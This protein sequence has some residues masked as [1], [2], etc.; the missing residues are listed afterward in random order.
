MQSE[1]AIEDAARALLACEDERRARDPLTAADWPDLTVA[2][3]YRVQDA[4]AR[5]RQARGERIVG[6]KMGLTSRAKQAT[7]GV[8]VP[9]VAWVTDRMRV[10]DEEAPPLD[11]FIH[12]R[13]EPELFFRLGRPLSG[14]ALTREDAAAAVDLVVAGVD[15]I[16]SRY[17]DFRFTLADVVAD[18][19]SSAGFIPGPVQCDPA[20]LDL[21]LESVIVEQDGV[22]IDTATGA[23]I[24]GHPL[25]A[26]AA[27]ANLLG[28]RGLAL[29]AGSWV[30]AG[31]MTDAV[32][33][34]PS[35]TLAFHFAHLGSIW[36]PRE[37]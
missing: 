35:R 32:A 18:N 34:D 33:I 11:R 12:P 9:A 30:L 21:Q 16:D 27:A 37:A 31:A 20:D 26:V 4:S 2:D 5:M 7:M 23:V 22:V 13:A 36:I 24:L 10:D 15:I 28:E 1:A 25:D 3:A 29:D 6:V 19:A 8:D 14:T 17:H